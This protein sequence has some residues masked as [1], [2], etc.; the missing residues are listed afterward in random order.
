MS[1]PS[2]PS[3]IRI[4]RIIHAIHLVREIHA[5]RMQY[6]DVLGGLVFSEGYFP[7][8]D[9]DMALLYAADF[10]IE[11]MA[12]RDPAKTQFAIARYLSRYGE[13]WHSFE[14]K[15]ENAKEAAARLKA[16][17]CTLAG[18]Y[19]VFFF[20]RQESTGGIL[21]EVCQTPMPNDPYDRP[22]WNPRWAD[23]IPC[24]LRRLDHIACAVKE[25]DTPLRFFTELLDGRILSDERV[26]APQPARRVL[27]R[28]GDKDVAFICP[29]DAGS[30]PV[31]AFLGKPNS[32]I[33]ALV[34]AVENAAQ[35]KAVFADKGLRIV[36]E[37]CIG[38]S[39]A[40]DPRDF[41]NA[42]HEFKAV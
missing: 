10:M 25:L 11:P 39:F 20:V 29:D 7:A 1:N 33:Y 38:G 31:G 21:L 4:P 19:D 26:T 22:N 12:P 35:A 5:A 37:G 18:V 28:I 13:G 30:G 34:W 14:V 32:G 40:I 24:G 2:T 23:G 3:P 9:R 42:R 41:H 27:I 16:A 6:L 8:E 17:G 36:V 15:V